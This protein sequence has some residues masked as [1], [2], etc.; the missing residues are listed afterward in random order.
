MGDFIHALFSQI[1]RLFGLQYPGTGLTFSQI[2][3]GLFVVGVSIRILKD[4][5]PLA[6]GVSSSA[7]RGVRSRVH[8][9]RYDR[10]GSDK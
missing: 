10:K 8:R 9:A 7:V 2:F 5:G 6:G 1:W 4:L 3:L